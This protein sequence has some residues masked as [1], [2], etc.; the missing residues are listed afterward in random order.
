MEHHFNVNIATKYGIEEAILI[1][2]L[3]FWISKNVANEKHKHDGRYW[4][5]NTSKAFS[6]IFPYLSESTIYRVMKSLVEKKIICKGNY[7][8]DKYLRTSWYAF[9]DEG[10]KALDE[11]KYD[12][13]GF[14][15][16]YR[17]SDG[18][19]LTISSNGSDESA[20]SST[21][22][23]DTDNNHKKEEDKS[24]SEKEE[25]TWREDF[26][27][28]LRCVYEARD[29]L[30]KNDTYRAQIAQYYPNADYDKTINAEV[31]LYWGTDAAWEKRKKSRTKS[32]D[33][34]KTLKNNFK[35]NI[36]YKPRSFSKQEQDNDKMYHSKK[37]DAG[38]VYHDYAG[39]GTERYRRFIKWLSDN[40]TYIYEHYTYLITLN[41]FTEMV[42]VGGTAERMSEIILALAANPT[43]YVKYDNLYEFVKEKLHEQR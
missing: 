34:V 23:K 3:Y 8:E 11:E 21:D 26:D 29:K 20:K 4:T 24:S 19:D 41:Q 43:E 37:R 35:R 14:S 12:I 13:K 17:Q 25:K 1:E 22:N 9:T 40:A 5:Y 10:I 39:Y 7:N 42:K 30:L 36:I 15:N 16:T 33:M 2:N 27:V 18:M 38:S 28:F 6:V 32:L 31:D